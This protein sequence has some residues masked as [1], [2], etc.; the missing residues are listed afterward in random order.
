MN[1]LE[2]LSRKEDSGETQSRIY[3]VVVGVVT[4]NQD[5][6]K[7]GRVK[8]SFPWLKEKA[9]S[10]WA[11]VASPMAGNDRG[12]VFIPEVKD[13]VLVAFQQGDV[14]APYV[15]GAL[16][17]GVDKFIKEKDGD[18]NNNLRIIKSR[19]NHLIVLDDTSGSEKIQI[20]DSKGK[21][22]I[23][24]DSQKNKITIQGEGDIELK[25]SNG[26]IIL[27]AQSVEIKSSAETKVEAGSTM[28]V[29]A[30]STMT[31]KGQMV[32]IN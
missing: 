23:T 7:L 32:N 4:D 11:R 1:L 14:R 22:T 20:I 15:I 12:L 29:K 5:P 10:D 21:N 16:W 17:N 27:D 28:D 3:G 18:D 13:E 24:I 25:A 31:I 26:K 9:E 8:V 30:S 2:I 19:S 6:D